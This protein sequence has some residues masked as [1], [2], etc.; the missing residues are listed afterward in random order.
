MWVRFSANCE[1]GTRFQML[2]EQQRWNL[3]YRSVLFGLNERFM[4]S[5]LTNF[6]GSKKNPCLNTSW[7]KSKDHVTWPTKSPKRSREW[8]HFL[9]TKFLDVFCLRVSGGFDGLI[10]CK[11]VLLDVLISM[12]FWR[13][14]D[15][16]LRSLI[17]SPWFFNPV[18]NLSCIKSS[19]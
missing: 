1:K 5:F 15:F 9:V 4:Y 8:Q 2:L 13:V 10:C 12:A 19:V 16:S 7:P 3:T 6:C 17:L 18:I 14:G 11:A